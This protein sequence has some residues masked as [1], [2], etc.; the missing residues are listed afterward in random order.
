MNEDVTEN[1]IILN[2]TKTVSVRDS[3]EK[4]GSALNNSTVKFSSLQLTTES[5]PNSPTH[6]ITG[7]FQ[8]VRSGV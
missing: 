8:D 6:N 7:S 2:A 3:V 1:T 4:A 5:E